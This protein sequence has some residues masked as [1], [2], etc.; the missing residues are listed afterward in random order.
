MLEKRWNPTACAAVL[1]LGL[2][3]AGPAGAVVCAINWDPKDN[4][5]TTT[6]LNGDGSVNGMDLGVLLG[7]WGDCPD[8]ELDGDP[9]TDCPADFNQDG[10]VGC[11]DQE[12]LL[13]NWGR[14]EGLVTEAGCEDVQA[15]K[16]ALPL[17]TVLGDWEELHALADGHEY[18]NE[19]GNVPSFDLDSS[20]LVDLHDVNIINCLLADSEAAPPYGDVN[21]DGTLDGADL[22]LVL[23]AVGQACPDPNQDGQIGWPDLYVLIESWKP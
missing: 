8:P 14:C 22:G 3:A 13:G 12:F 11:I 21:L 7:A 5:F 23:G 10:K 15:L 9:D 16:D 4:L 19:D 18:G 1:F 17:C 20:G 2:L 6:D